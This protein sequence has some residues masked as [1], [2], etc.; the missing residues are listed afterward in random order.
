MRRFSIYFTLFLISGLAAFFISNE[1]LWSFII[2]IFTSSFLYIIVNIGS[3][4]NRS[5]L[6]FLC[7]TVYRKLHI[8]FS[9]SYLYRIKVDDKYLLVRGNRL[10]DQFQPVGGVYKRYLGSNHIFRK[11]NILDDEH[12]PIDDTSK[13][14]LRVLVPA[15]HVIKFLKWYESKRDRETTPEREFKEELVETKILSKKY[16]S[17]I[18]Y[19]FLRTE[20]TKI[21]F[22]EYFQCREILIADI[23][24]VI[25]NNSQTK[26]LK[27]LQGVEST[28]YAWVE[29]NAIRRRGYN[30][31]KSIRI[32]NTA[33][34]II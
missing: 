2:G 17:S 18:K 31:K 12:M 26:E 6:T 33:E 5:W 4:N 21:K 29:A 3:I 10:K 20:E 25:L 24:N 11:Y 16:F 13:D 32:S 15:R 28:Q 27:K 23:Y 22:S 7:K 30:K 34:W 9:I 14:D 19:E 1:K 8:R